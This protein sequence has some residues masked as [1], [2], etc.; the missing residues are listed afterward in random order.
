MSHLALGRGDGQVQGLEVCCILGSGGEEPAGYR[1]SL[2]GK[3]EQHVRH[4]VG[5][6]VCF[7]Y[8][9]IHIGFDTDDIQCH[10]I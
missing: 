9:I 4:H 2:E 1:G 10:Q 8:K 7:T 3:T 5:W 6:F